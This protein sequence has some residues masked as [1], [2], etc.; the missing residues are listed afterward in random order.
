MALDKEFLT[1]VFEG[2]ENAE[3]R[4]GK[5]LKEY[6][7]DTTGLK[8]TRDDIKKEKEG[9][10]AKLDELA[11]LSEKE[12]AD[13][14]KQIEE[15]EKQVK[16]SGGEELKAVYEAEKTKLLEM[17]AAKLSELEKARDG[18]KSEHEKLYSEYLKVLKN[19]ELDKAM[20]SLPNLKPELKNILR[21]AFWARNQFEYV[22][23]E[24][25][26]ELRSG[27]E[28]NYRTIE[29]TLRAFISTDEGKSFVLNNS[30][31]GG[32]TGGSAP[33]KPVIQNP[34]AKE[35]FNLTEQMK[36]E[37]ADPAKATALRE[38]AGVKT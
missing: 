36:L 33:G 17:H 1:G 3:E 31:G 25:R 23:F 14:Q 9:Y 4:I 15:L 19:T 32:A 10:K 6:E 35:T 11:A 20:N 2:V 21:D 12:K 24:G 37:K 30:T 29:D 18:Y 13:L 8:I 27:K 5:V 38:S 26:K 34:Y 7:S 22:D 28:T 16:A